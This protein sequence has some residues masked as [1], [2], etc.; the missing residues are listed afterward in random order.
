MIYV[1]VS[2]GSGWGW[3]LPGISVSV[4]VNMT[5]MQ[6]LPMK[7]CMTRRGSG[8]RMTSQNSDR[9]ISH[10]QTSGHLVSPARTSPSLESREDCVASEV[11]SITASLTSSKA[12]RKVINPHTYLLR[13]L[14]TCFQLMEASILPPFCLKWTKQG[15]TQDGRCLTPKNTES[16]RTGRGCSLS[17]ILEAEADG[18][19]YLSQEKT[20]E[21]L[22][23]L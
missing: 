12:R 20:E 11:E 19:Y 23:K 5:N 14:R 22:K 16:P 17:Q 2:V 21:L 1:Q 13:T 8:K 18:K 10:M 7:P 9:G 3:R 6:G 15:M 4:I